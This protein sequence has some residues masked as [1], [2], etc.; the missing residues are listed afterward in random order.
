VHCEPAFFQVL[1]AF[2]KSNILALF[3]GVLSNRQDTV[4]DYFGMTTFHGAENLI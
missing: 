3:S 2:L 1:V 4:M